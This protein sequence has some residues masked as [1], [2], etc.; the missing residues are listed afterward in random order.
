M[1][2]L[3]TPSRRGPECATL[4]EK[5]IRKKVQLAPTIK[6][7]LSLLRQGQFS[8]VVLDEN[9]LQMDPG[10]IDLLLRRS[11]T[12]IPVY[13]NLGTSGPE[14]VAQEVRA[15]QQRRVEEQE[16]SLEAAEARLRSELRADVTAL[17]LSSEMAMA[18][19]PGKARE[20]IVSI[21]E[22]A[23]RIKNRLRLG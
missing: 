18:A 22:I 13:I 2:L 1:I 15:A 11:G 16:L 6:A 9:L 21:H 7:G 23:E 19:T 12:A 14:R 8:V 4:L 20:K 3:I 10:E 5:A 17:L